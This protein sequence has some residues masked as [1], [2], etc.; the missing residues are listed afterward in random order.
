MK[1]YFITGLVILLPLAVTLFVIL[2]LFNLL[3]DPLAGI[4]ASALDRYDLL[5]GDYFFIS[6]HKVQYFISQLAILVLLF[7]ITV[8]LG[9]L[10]R[11][12]FFNSLLR[13]WDWLIHRIPLISTIYK[14]SQDVINTVFTSKTKSF[15]QVVVVKFP[16]PHTDSVGLLTQ[17]SIKGLGNPDDEYA[18]VFVP[19][20]PNPTSGFLILYPKKD[21]VYIDMKVEDAFKYVISCGVLSPGFKVIS[22]EEAKLKAENEA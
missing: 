19:T 9:I 3:T 20:T 14:A 21:L 12:I 8:F 7:F 18:A 6:G 10:A 16:N 2:F 4:V 22:Y 15:K 11:Y 1:K 5:E 17:D 13:L